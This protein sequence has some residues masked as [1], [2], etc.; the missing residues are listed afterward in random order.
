[1]E[2]LLSLIDDATNALVDSGLSLVS[3]VTTIGKDLSEIGGTTTVP[4]Q[5]LR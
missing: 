3:L 5:K 4:G 1:M 2:G